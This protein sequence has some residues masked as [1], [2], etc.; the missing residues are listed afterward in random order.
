MNSSTSKIVF[1]CL[2]YIFAV[3]K[4]EVWATPLEGQI[5]VDPNNPAWLVYNR[6]KNN[7][8]KLDPFFMCGPGD[9]EGFLYRG[10]RM[11]NGTR[12]GDQLEILDA[13]K[14]TGANSIY[15]QIIRSHGGDGSKDPADPARGKYQNPFVDGDPTKGL[16]ENILDQWENWFDIMDQNGIVNFLFFYDD[17]IKV[18]Q[19]LGWN[20]KNGQLHKNEKQFIKQIVNRFKHHKNLIWVV[21][22]EVEEMGKDHI[23][24]AKKIAEAIRQFDEHRHVIAV[25]QL[26]GINFL[27]PDDFNID[28]FAVQLGD[29]KWTP[30]MVHRSTVNAWFRAQGKY[31]INI[32]EIYDHYATDHMHKGGIRR[33]AS[34][35]R[36]VNW[37]A[38][39]GGGYIMIYTWNYPILDKN[40]LKQC[41][42]LRRFF[43]ET[44][45]NEMSPHDNLAYADTKWVMAKPGHSYIAYSDHLKKSIGIKSMVSEKYNFIWMDTVS[46]NRVIQKSVS[47]SAGNQEWE[48][49]FGFGSEVAVYISK[50]IANHQKPPYNIIS[51]DME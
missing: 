30:Q 49:P 2:L 18:G 28:Q 14:G 29:K 24:H 47:V 27:F 40:V 9:P 50:A 23:R 17:A 1:F 7:D 35:V 15:I 21:M 39:M 41:G 33:P 34:H 11:K 37:A 26:T 32:A 44:D 38:A 42:Y 12:N 3:I 5:I 46:G 19:S 16:N 6:D 4:D 51:S 31:N 10:Q 48:K 8:G 45:F 25:H 13:I 22:E 20:L 36:K 43:E